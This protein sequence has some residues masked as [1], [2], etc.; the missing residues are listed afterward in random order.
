MLRILLCLQ[1][2][3]KCLKVCKYCKVLQSFHIEK[4]VKK[5][6]NVAKPTVMAEFAV[7]SNVANI[8]G[9]LRL[10]SC[11][12]RFKKERNK[13]RYNVAEPTAM[14][15]LSKC[16]SASNVANIAAPSNIAKCCR[17]LYKKVGSLQMLQNLQ[18]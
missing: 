12:I 17:V 6:A 11:C 1:N 9:S 8:A 3:A 18:M 5:L 2:I 13:K 14:E 16:C 4:K 15:E 7:L 10:C